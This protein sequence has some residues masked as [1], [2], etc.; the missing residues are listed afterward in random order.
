M[1][2]TFALGLF[3]IAF[4]SCGSRSEKTK[5][6][7]EKPVYKEYIGKYLYMSSARVL[8]TDRYCDILLEE[9]DRSGHDVNGIA[10]MDTTNICPDGHF[11]YCKSCFD[12]EQYEHVQRIIERNKQNVAV[13]EEELY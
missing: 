10:F 9:K 11:Y 5:E 8:H 3:A 13:S 6:N 7:S 12:D 2:K 4:V 1:K